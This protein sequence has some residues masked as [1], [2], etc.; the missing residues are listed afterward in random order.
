MIFLD[1][2]VNII[3]NHVNQLTYIFTLLVNVFEL[4][5]RRDFSNDFTH[6]LFLH[7]SKCVVHS[8]LIFGADD[9]EFSFNDRLYGSI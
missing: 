6:E 4:L 9:I 7:S 8:L 5:F 2:K 1:L 3:R